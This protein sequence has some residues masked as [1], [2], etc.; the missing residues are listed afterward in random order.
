MLA[1]RLRA[2]C[3]LA[4]LV[5]VVAVPGVASAAGPPVLEASWVTD[6]TASSVNLRAEIDPEG[7]LTHFRFEYRGGGTAGAVPATGEAVVGS[8]VTP[9]AVVRSLA[10]LG[11]STTYEYRVRVTNASGPVEGPW[12]T[13]TTQASG[14]SFA[15]LDGRGWE[16]VSPVDKNGGAI[17]TVGT[18]APRTLQAAAAG[19]AVTYSAASAF[20]TAAGAPVVSQYLSR[21]GDAGWETENLTVPL[22]SGSYGSESEISPYALF[23]P[24]L[25]RALFLNGVR[26]R[27]ADGECPVANPPL[28][29]T[30]APAGYQDLYL[31]EG[32]GFT[33]LVG[34]GDV[35]HSNLSPA[36]FAVRLV[37]ASP[38][39]R[40]AVLSTCAA[41]S[42]G[43]TEATT[44]TGCETAEANL[45]EWSAG[46]L[47]QVNVLPGTGV[48]APGATVAAGGVSAD[49]ARVYWTGA[50][51]NLYLWTRGGGSVEVDGGPGGGSFQVASADGSVAFFT[52]EGRLFRFAAAAGTA[53][54][55]APGEEVEA[56][57][58]ASEAGNVVYYVTA[59]G[60]RSWT[61][62]TI[63]SVAAGAAPGDGPPA[64]GTARVS[65]DG[66]H[67][68]FLSDRSLTGYDNAGRT[69]VYLYGGPGA[70][71]PTLTCVSCNPTGER[72]RGPS[73]IPGAVADGAGP[74]AI[75]LYKP[76]SLA[77]GGGRVF[78]DSDD[79][80]VPEDTNSVPDAYEWEA[81]G[82]GTCTETRGCVQLLGDGR[83]PEG[84]SFVDASAS[85]ADAYFL[86]DGSLVPGDPGVVDLYDA[87]E[88]GG[89][90]VPGQPVPCDGD[91]CQP[92]PSPPEDPTPG[93]LV[94]NSGNP[95]AVPL[96]EEAKAKKK[97]KKKLKGHHRRGHGKKSSKAK[98]QQGKKGKRDASGPRKGTR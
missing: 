49:G 39:L 41:L 69:E 55:V 94:H 80:L 60:V 43:A 59:A 25:T 52:K 72:P 74:E 1:G 47:A 65:P 83:S 20:G 64:T 95:P 82:V 56:V 96:P 11:P 70:G 6:V 40:H 57:L 79:A 29:G 2:F 24:D 76:R 85:G 28:P 78:F 68:L 26:C 91:A 88:G 13:F 16:M 18:A 5:T 17:E 14:Q 63:A 62:G 21:R 84:S 45:Y 67:L 71:G 4:V 61:S 3:A 87:R 31:R 9:I 97:P 86:T 89:F 23:S 93:T 12:R 98:A 73:S 36:Q 51:G 77:D 15:L 7:S 46:G 27:D 22:F 66:S 50:D 10:A 54:E 44:A 33:A 90:P 35:A 32:A 19:G 37:A 30:E 75:A 81:P 58:G 34:R 42:A 8:G 53:V 38:D 92:L 48:G